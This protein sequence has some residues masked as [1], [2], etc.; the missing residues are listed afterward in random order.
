MHK[1]TDNQEYGMRRKANVRASERKKRIRYR[2]LTDGEN[3]TNGMEWIE[4]WHSDK[5][6]QSNLRYGGHTILS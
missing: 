4:I 2:I 3:A 1:C 6:L 5:K